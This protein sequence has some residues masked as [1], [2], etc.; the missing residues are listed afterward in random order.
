MEEHTGEHTGEQTIWTMGERWG[1][2]KENLEE[3]NAKAYALP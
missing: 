3:P 1:T 2:I